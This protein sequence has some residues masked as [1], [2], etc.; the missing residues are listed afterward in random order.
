MVNIN[1]I[2]TEYIKNSYVFVEWL[3]ESHN[4]QIV[5]SR[6]DDSIYVCKFKEYYN[7]GIYNKIK[8]NHYDGIPEIYELMETGD[9]LIII[10]EYI[11]GNRL[12]EIS[13][14]DVSSNIESWICN[15]GIEVC[16]ILN[17]IHQE[18][19]PIIHRDIKPQNIILSG[20]KIYLVDFNIAKE[21]SGEKSKDTFIM[22]TREFAAPEQYGF[23]ESDV[24]TDIYG[25]G[26]TLKYLIEKSGLTSAKL[27]NIVKRATEIDPN[28][29]YQTVNEVVNALESKRADTIKKS[30]K[31]YM[32]PGFRRGNIF[33]MLCSGIFYLIWGWMCLT[34]EMIPNPYTGIAENVYNWIGRMMLF[35]VIWFI[36]CLSFNYLGF[37]DKV[38]AKIGIS[39]IKGIKK[40]LLI[41]LLDFL[42][43]SFIF[44]FF[45]LIGFVTLG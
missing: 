33:Y 9:G 31:K 36:I 2:I 22:G 43:F 23:S 17:Q 6:I 42:F 37:Q 26:A 32:L 11:S 24:R 13:I 4:I 29:R 25:I 19:P 14:Q 40:A 34:L 15:I 28:N 12:D 30:I 45:V 39:N 41:I 18:K 7:I 20:N 3:D 21:Y 10:E 38:F 44:T 5:K 16:K 27:E 1:E 35:S 8:K